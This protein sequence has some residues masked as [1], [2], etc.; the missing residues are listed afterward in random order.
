VFGFS[1]R[2]EGFEDRNDDVD[3]RRGESDDK[4]VLDELPVCCIDANL[5]SKAAIL[6]LTLER[7]NCQI[8]HFV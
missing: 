3:D 6:L 1:G 7:E 2:K 8:N 4:G 5:A